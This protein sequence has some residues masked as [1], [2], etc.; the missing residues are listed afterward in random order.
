MVR[1]PKNI[2]GHCDE[3]FAIWD[4]TNNGKDI[5]KCTNFDDFRN[6]AMARREKSVLAEHGLAERWNKNTAFGIIFGQ[7]FFNFFLAEYGST[8]YIYY[9][10]PASKTED[11]TE[12]TDSWA[13]DKD[14]NFIR[15]NL[16]WLASPRRIIDYKSYTSFFEQQVTDL[17]NGINY[18]ALFID[19]QQEADFRI[20]GFIEANGLPKRIGA[21][22]IESRIGKNNPACF[23]RFYEDLRENVDYYNAK[24]AQ[25]IVEM[26]DKR[27]KFNNSQDKFDRADIKTLT[28]INKGAGIATP[29]W[30][31]TA[32]TAFGS[33]GPRIDEGPAYYVSR[34]KALVEQNVR[35]LVELVRTTDNKIPERVL[36]GSFTE[37][38]MYHKPPLAIG[39]F[40]DNA[41]LIK[42]L[43]EQNIPSIIGLVSYGAKQTLNKVLDF[44][45]SNNI[46]I[47]I[48]MDEALEIFNTSLNANE[49]DDG[50]IEETMN[51]IDKLAKLEQEGLLKTC[52]LYDAIFTKG[53]IYGMNASRLGLPENPLFEHDHIQGQEEGRLVPLKIMHLEIP[54]YEF[55]KFAKHLDDCTPA[56]I[57]E[58]HG[59]QKAWQ[60]IKESNT[61]AA[62][63]LAFNS[64]V[65]TGKKIMDEMESLHTPQVC[66]CIFADTEQARR[67]KL[68][69][70]MNDINVE[71][72]VGNRHITAKGMN[73]NILENII[74]APQTIQKEE[75][76]HHMIHR[77]LRRAPGERGR[78]LDKCTKQSGTLFLISLINADGSTHK[79][80]EVNHQRIRQLKEK[81]ILVIEQKI[82]TKAKPGPDPAPEPVPGPA[83]EDKKLDTIQQLTDSFIVEEGMPEQFKILEA[84]FIGQKEIKDFEELSQE[85][86]LYEMQQRLLEEGN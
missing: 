78:P 20:T 51:V 82:S 70:H 34:V 4:L 68:Q 61:K 45:I 2:L 31:K 55:N 30:G 62:K 53:S 47:R 83:V 33:I 6:L 15:V 49:D 63:L 48:I 58:N 57:L 10:G 21:R 71:V 74:I 23:Q 14:G 42:R 18:S 46:P 41:K 80:V 50:E 26:D 56:Q 65:E 75:L 25:A 79:S 22:S 35:E 37:H 43:H 77:C 72:Y 24:R 69:E 76:F 8:Y 64:K 3:I 7:P 5:L 9:A 11:L 39:S 54:E 13:K 19:G 1:A 59:I 44:H 29:G 40:G 67:V 27:K 36:L 52:H 86:K 38:E 81:G 84:E 32:L 12:A 60:F 85:D 17:R 73:Y 16:K 66:G 28:S